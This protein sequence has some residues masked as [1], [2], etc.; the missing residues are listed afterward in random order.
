MKKHAQRR[1]GDDDDDI[2][3]SDGSAGDGGDGGDAGDGGGGGSVDDVVGKSEHKGDINSQGP[4]T[5]L[6]LLPQW[7][8]ELQVS[9]P[10]GD[11]A[12]ERG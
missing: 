4:E 9:I 10:S 11:R 6:Y 3:G 2:S 7:D 12:G 1:I 5:L 8:L